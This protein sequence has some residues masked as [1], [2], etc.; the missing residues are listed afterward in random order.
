MQPGKKERKKIRFFK[1]LGK[2]VFRQ[3]DEQAIGPAPWTCISLFEKQWEDYHSL[4]QGIFST[5]G[6]NLCLLHLLHWQVDSLPIVAPEKSKEWIN[7]M[8][9]IYTVEYYSAIKNN[10]IMLFAAKWMDLEN[11]MLNEVNREWEISYDIPF[12][13]NLKRNYTNE[14]PYKTETHRQKMNLWLLGGQD[15]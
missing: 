15:S 11:I 3:R 14:L 13:W 6:L 9:Y 4:L 2:E 8:W 1:T 7:K 12:V 10:E 5:Q